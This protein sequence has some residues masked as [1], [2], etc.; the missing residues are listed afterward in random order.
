MSHG[1]RSTVSVG[2]ERRVVKTLNR[3]GTRAYMPK[4]HDG[5][6]YGA[7]IIGFYR[8]TLMLIQCQNN[9]RRAMTPDIVWELK[10][11]L[12]TICPNNTVGILVAN[13][14]CAGT[15]MAAEEPPH[16]IILATEN[17]VLEKIAQ[18]FSTRPYDPS[19]QVDAIAELLMDRIKQLEFQ[20]ETESTN[21]DRS[22]KEREAFEL[23][24]ERRLSHIFYMLIFILICILAGVATFV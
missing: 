8:K 10:T 15:R 9:S 21:L 2:S 18:V 13:D 7:D 5:E 3:A 17:D 19:P 12:L 1:T 23:Q 6:D 22:R 14:F 4:Q 16:N 24:Q 11:T 20:L